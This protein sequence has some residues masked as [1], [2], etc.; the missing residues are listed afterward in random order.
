M[1]VNIETSSKHKWLTFWNELGNIKEAELI[2]ISS[3][4]IIWDQHPVAQRSTLDVGIKL[5]IPELKT[6]SEQFGSKFYSLEIS[7]YQNE[8]I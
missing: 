7:F 8:N 4:V 1:F 5:L 2:R 3:S 6:K